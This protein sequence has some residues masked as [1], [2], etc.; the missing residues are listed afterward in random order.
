[1]LKE[2]RAPKDN[3]LLY[4]LKAGSTLGVSK[5]LSDLLKLILGDVDVTFFNGP[6]ENK[7][8]VTL[9]PLTEEES[10]LVYDFDYDSLSGSTKC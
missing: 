3:Y 1:M 7:A 8:V 5:S 2:G 10:H 9:N 6:P 4:S